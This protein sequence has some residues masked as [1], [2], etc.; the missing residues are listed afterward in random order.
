MSAGLISSLE[1]RRVLSS[2]SCRWS[3]HP[4]P[5]RAI[6]SRYFARSGGTRF[7]FEFFLGIQY[8]FGIDPAPG[9]PNQNRHRRLNRRCPSCAPRWFCGGMG[10]QE[11]SLPPPRSSHDRRVVSCAPRWF[12][13]G[14]GGQAA[15][16]PTPLAPATTVGRVLRS[17]MICGGGGGGGRV[18]PLAPA[19]HLWCPSC[20]P[21]LSGVRGR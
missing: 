9:T 3:T 21:P 2:T 14:M 15:S 12:C 8:F 5:S 20:A 17:P 1:G 16:P 13:G 18:S 10:G 11:A 4:I 7:L 19:G 6:P